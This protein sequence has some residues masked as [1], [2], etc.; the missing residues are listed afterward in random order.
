[1]SAEQFD[2]IEDEMEIM[3][4]LLIATARMACRDVALLRLYI[5]FRRGLLPA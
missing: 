5:L 3:K 2:R 1:M 4:E